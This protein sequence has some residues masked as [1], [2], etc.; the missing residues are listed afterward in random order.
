MKRELRRAMMDSETFVIE[1]VYTDS[2]GQ[3][4]RRTISPIRFVSD[5]RM[6]AL[7][8][9]R[10]EPRQFYL[11]RCSDVRLVPAAEVMMPMP[12]QTVPAPATHVIPAVA[13]A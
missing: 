12:I 13:L 11:S 7:C 4:S 6:L 8:L 10:E 5:D 3:Q 9:C 1:M 2:K